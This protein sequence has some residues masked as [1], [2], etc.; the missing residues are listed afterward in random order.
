MKINANG[1]IVCKINAPHNNQS[2]VVLI[3]I[4]TFAKSSS[5]TPKFF[6][7]SIILTPVS[8]LVTKILSSCV[9]ALT[10]GSETTIF[11]ISP[12]LTFKAN[13]FKETACF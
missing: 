10:S 8:L 11:F 13:S 2:E 5:V 4:C 12:F 3:S 1:K 7:V 6:N 9:I